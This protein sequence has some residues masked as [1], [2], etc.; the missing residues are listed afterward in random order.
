MTPMLRKFFILA[1]LL[2]I[3]FPSAVLAQPGLPAP[4]AQK[5]SA[6]DAII[7]FTIL[8]TNDF[9]GQLEPVGTSNPGSA[10]VAGVVEGVRTS[11][12]AENVLL[13]DIGDEMQGSLLSNIWKGQ[14]VIDVYN[15]M[16]YDAATFG[17]H[18]F[19]W[20][21]ANLITRTLQATYPYLAANIVVN[22]TGNCSTAGWT[23]PT[24]AEP[25]TTVTVGA[26]GAQVTVGVIGVSSVETPYIT[27]ASAT[28][29]LCFKDPYTSIARYYAALD[30]ASDVIV[31]LSHNGLE[32]GGYGYGFPVFG[33]K[34]LAKN[35]NDNGMPVSLIIG[36]HSHTNMTSAYVYGA[37]TVVQA[38]YNGR[39]VGRADLTYNTDT[40]AVTV[41]WQSLTVPTTGTGDANVAAI[42]NS[43][44]SDPEYLALI[45][46]TIGYTN[47]PLVRN[48]DGD[49]MM[50]EF[51]QDAVYEDLNNDAETLNDVD[52]V[53]NNAGGIRADITGPSYPFTMTYGLL[54]NVLP[55]GNATAVGDMTGAQIMELL[56]QSATLFKGAI[57]VAGVRYKFYKYADALP[58]PQPYAWGAYDAEVKNKDTGVWEPLDMDRTYR[59]A[60]NEFLAPAG[61]DG[62][63]PF[64]YM[65]NI[66]YWGDMLNNV[67]DWVAQTYGTRDTAYNGPNDDGQL[68]GRI[69]RD[70]TDAGGSIVP[71]TVLHH[72]DSHGRLLKSGSYQGLTQL[73][74]IIK[75][76]RRHNPDRT[77]LLNAG[78][79]IQGD[80]MSYYFKSAGLGYAADGTVLPPE[81]QMNPFIAATN[82]MTY[83]AMVPGNH[84]FN[85]GR[86][87]FTSTLKDANYPII[88]AN[89][90]DDGQYGIAEVGVE[91]YTEVTLDG[92]NVAILGIGNHRVPNYELPSNIPGLTFSNPIATAQALAPGLKDTND[93]VI[94]LTH[95]GFTG[96]PSSV[97]VDENVDTE[98]AAQ[99]T[100]IDAIIGG[101]S[102][103]D[104]SKATSASGAY[105][106]LPAIVG[107]PDNTPVIINQSYRYNTY[108]GEV[109]LGLKPKAG[110]G[111]EVV[112]R[113]GRAISVPIATAEDP[114]VKAIVDP[115]NALLTAYNNTVI[116]QTTAPIDTMAAF[117]E[118]TNG[119]NLQADA[120]VAELE[121]NGIPVDFHLSGA[122]TNKLIATTATVTE[123]YTL[124]VSDMFSAM[125]YENSLLVL[126]MNGPQL[127]TVLERA[128]RNYYYYNYV[129]GYGGYSYYTTCM[130]DTNAGNQIVYDDTYP[131]LPNGNNVVSLNIGGNLV[132]FNDAATYYRVSTVNYLAA[133]S[134]NFNDG[135][136]S[137]WPLDQIAADTQYYVRDAVINYITDQGVVSPAIEGRL[138][139]VPFNGEVNAVG[140]A[141]ATLIFPNDGMG[142][143]LEIP[144]DAVDD[145]IN[146]VYRP[147]AAPAHPT[148]LSFAGN[149]FELSAYQGGTELPGYNFNGPI[150]IALQYSDAAVAGLNEDLIFLYFWDGDSWEDAA[151][152]PYERHPDENWLAVEINHFTSFAALVLDYGANVA[153]AVNA[154]AANPGETV[155]YTLAVTSTGNAPDTFDVSVSGNTWVTNAPATVGPLNPGVSQ[156]INVTVEIPAGTLAGAQDA[157]TVT[158]TSQ[159]DS[160]KLAAATLTTTA[161][162]VYG[163]TVDPQAAT[164]GANPGETVSFTLQV[165]N[166]GNVPD[167][168]DVDVS[169]NTW[170]TQ[171]PVTV[172][173]VAAFT[174]EAITVTVEIPAGAAADDEDTATVSFS[175]Q[176]DD[177]KT[178]VATLTSQARI[179]YGLAVVAEAEMQSGRPGDALTYQL[180]VTNTGNVAET[181]DIAVSGNVFTT[182]A[183][184]TAGAI[185][186]GATAVF[187]VTVEIPA[188]AADGD[189]DATTITVTS[190]QDETKQGTVE[191]VT[192]VIVAPP[193]VYTISLPLVTTLPPAQK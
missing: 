50:G 152:G 108:L 101:H 10:R 45:N 27:V 32:D 6:P 112:T 87:V 2:S 106:Y 158:L 90:S 23:S 81:L 186:P 86:Q 136:V 103:T 47:V 70:G 183:P 166:A 77:I 176:N 94:A 147:L 124:T 122:M 133:G 28:E 141:G 52:M 53:F 4:A 165:A 168:F 40:Q 17:N 71:V 193:P 78:D 148:A 51:L 118:E 61:Q 192:K 35:L 128:Y 125:P 109:V 64:K 170:A 132:D 121:N 57:Q 69:A 157:A 82:A 97:E 100:G 113:A 21:Q 171:A 56:N 91:P 140:P 164:R 16:G 24:F 74:T 26:P 42:V 119:A 68:D 30:A 191:L 126:E 5:Q 174:S 130:I 163:V 154:Q 172:G 111:Y 134:C 150:T 43:Y 11:V 66:S 75:Q 25:W 49:S 173:P 102:H 153:P 149:A 156:A 76:E 62:Y 1:L 84:E 63:T 13:F 120:S 59:V 180:V 88:Q 105:K 169:G 31:V 114:A 159:G 72:N 83:T 34:T 19:D 139:F 167:T 12:G 89:V 123:P 175:S 95:I 98:L 138:Q 15:E 117:T 185:A 162:T 8:H 127:K 54:F 58:G 142:V 181:Y 184:A 179:V 146:V 116:G 96:N 29:G 104:P 55:F 73:A 93:A 38:Y 33:D 129:P 151:V 9:H 178:T 161:K 48:Y 46:Q 79:S 137:L 41:A 14:P 44:A 60:T 80:S 189:Q 99:T 190:Q 135:G 187:E 160:A 3:I 36:G 20:G 177:S 144:G 155:T 39:R 92:I 85:F 110:G 107:A 182:T 18:E 188:D 143:A 65:T 131:T 37:T 145:P 22:D 67:N 7:P 115:Y